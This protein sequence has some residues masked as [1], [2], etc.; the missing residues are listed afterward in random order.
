MQYV[1]ESFQAAP[2]VS[3]ADLPWLGVRVEQYHLEAGELPA[4]H[5]AHHLLMLY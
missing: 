5:H 3:S 1:S 2:L 4:H